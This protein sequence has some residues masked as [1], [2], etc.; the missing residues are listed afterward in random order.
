MAAE[1]ARRHNDRIEEINALGK[2]IQVVSR[3]SNWKEADRYRPRVQEL[4]AA[5]PI[6][7]EIL[8]DYLSSESFYWLAQDNISK[9]EELWR[10]RP[11]LSQSQNG[12]LVRSWLA[13][14]LLARKQWDEAVTLLR[15]SLDE[16]TTNHI[17][18]GIIAIRIKLIAV[19]LEQG[20]LEEATAELKEISQLASENLDRQYMAFVQSYY[21]R[22]YSMQNNI[23]AAR[24]AYT[25]ALDL[26]GR[27]GMRREAQKVRATLDVI[28]EAR[29]EWTELP[30]LASS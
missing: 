15:I 22:L 8:V 17:I 25:K 18:R 23:P 11:N 2:Y 1:F 21:G 13:D 4:L 10:Q 28:D 14:C 9:I 12:H 29:T 26:F 20:K 16:V 5:G 7:D 3:Q 19:A 30:Q 24:E 27:L 6:P